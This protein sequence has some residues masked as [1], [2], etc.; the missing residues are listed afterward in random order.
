MAAAPKGTQV[1]WVPGL[2]H[3]ALCGLE[4]DAYRQQVLQFFDARLRGVRV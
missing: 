3:T 1:W 2:D 4:S